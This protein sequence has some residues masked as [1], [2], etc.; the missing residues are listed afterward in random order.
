MD[1]AWVFCKRPP[2]GN[3][4]NPSPHLS[5][6]QAKEVIK[7]LW[8][9]VAENDTPAGHHFD[10]LN[11]GDEAHDIWEWNHPEGW[12]RYFENEDDQG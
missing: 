5:V 4:E 7:G 8:K 12:E 11:F 1:F 2:H 6:G 3:V 10:L 9:F